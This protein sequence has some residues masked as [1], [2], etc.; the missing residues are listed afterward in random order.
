MDRRSPG[1]L[2]RN[3]GACVAGFRLCGPRK[4]AVSA[5]LPLI[6]NKPPFHPQFCSISNKTC[7]RPHLHSLA[8][9]V[10]RTRFSAWTCQPFCCQRTFIPIPSECPDCLGTCLAGLIE[11][12]CA[13]WPSSS[14]L[15]LCE[16]NR[17]RRRTYLLRRLLLTIHYALP[18]NKKP[19]VERRVQSLRLSDSTRSSTRSSLCS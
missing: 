15:L 14:A 4:P 12:H 18:Q 3:H 10:I 13:A 9:T 7:N 5:R 19:G 16:L 1:N 8:R 6:L 2:L 11:P 17:C